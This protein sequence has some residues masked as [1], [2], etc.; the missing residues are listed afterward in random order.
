[1]KTNLASRQTKTVQMTVFSCLII[2][3]FSSVS[4]LGQNPATGPVTGRQWTIP[5]P[6]NMPFPMAWIPAGTFTMGSPDNEP[7]RKADESPQTTVTL[8]KGYWLG[9]TEVTI[10]QW[11]AVTGQSLRDKVLQL[12]N[13]ETLYDFDGKQ[14]KERDFMHFDKN[15]P[16]KI[17]AN[18]D[19]RLPMY[20]VSW[21]EA[22]DFCKK[23]T[24]LERAHGRL[25]A[26]YEYT[27]PTEAQWEYACR[28][29]TAGPT[30]SDAS[31]DDL[32]WYVKNSFIGYTGKGLGNPPAGPRDVGAKLAN[33]WGMQDI[34]GN[35]WEWCR[36]WYG[37][38]PG[39]DVT[40][41]T[42]PK[43]GSYRVNRG[44]SFGS[45]ANDERS[46]NRAKNPPNETSAY[47][48]FR[49]A[50]CAVQR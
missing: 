6:G 2:L 21:N 9:A 44:G 39:G 28:A 41:P 47:R 17:M 23:L 31:L 8:T 33:K 42:G 30:Y 43:D 5:L 36:D 22:M 1:M 46:A 19:D 49:V 24:E 16:D 50:L 10:G 45:G 25:P 34:L 15:D 20:F 13:D 12:L 4:L 14:M 3:A 11:K 35:I 32:A 27:L 38:Y 40:D 7:G 48:G 29:G 26:G 37:P 18:E